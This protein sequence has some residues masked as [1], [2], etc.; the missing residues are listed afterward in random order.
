MTERSVV[1]KTPGKLDMRALTIFGMNAKPTTHTPIGFFGTGLKYAMAV[2][3]RE[4]LKVTIHTNDVMWEV[5]AQETNFR[6]KGFKTLQLIRHKRWLG[7]ATRDL[8]YT[9]EHGKTWELWQAFRELYSNTLDED[10]VAYIL[11]HDTIDDIQKDQTY[12]VVTGEKFVQE[13]L[14]REKTFLPDGLREQTTKEPVQVFDR[15]SD[16]I[17][18]RGIRVHNFGKDVK[19]QLTYNILKPIDLTEDRTAK[20]TFQL[21]QCIEEHVQQTENEEHILKVIAPAPKSYERSLTWDYGHYTA[22]SKLF[23]D[24]TTKAKDEGK[25]GIGSAVYSRVR[26]YLPPAPKVEDKWLNTMIEL[27][28]NLTNNSDESEFNTLGVHI[29]QEKDRMLKILES[30]TAEEIPF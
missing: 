28:Q 7:T 13:F 3:A 30:T 22:P 25:L 26:S 16:C 27:I 17:Y 24:T 15:P 10:G 14:E 1:F 23:I 8:P 2:L 19:S 29:L 12:I 11:D 4:G 20:Y 18:Y 6:G 9:T 21:A 5:K